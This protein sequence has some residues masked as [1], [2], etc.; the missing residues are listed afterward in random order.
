MIKLNSAIKN[1]TLVILSSLLLLSPIASQ[2][3]PQT[4]EVFSYHD[5][6]DQ[7]DGD[8]AADS[9]A[10]SSYNLARHFAWLKAHGYHPVSVDTILAARNNGKQLP[11]KAILLTFDD[12]YRSF[13]DRVY[14][15]LKLYQFPAVAAVVGGWLSVK[16]GEIVDYGDDKKPREHFLSNSQ[17][18]ELADSG[19]VEIASHSFDLHHGIQSNPQGNKTPAAITRAYNPDSKTYET[20][21]LYEARITADLN[22]NSQFIKEITG[23]RPRVMVWPYGAYNTQTSKIATDSGMPISLSLNDM[24]AAVLNTKNSVIGRFL[25]DQNPDASVLPLLLKR[26]LVVEH[27]RVI[28]IDLDYVYDA[29]LTQMN[30]NIDALLDRIKSLKPSTV[31]LQAFADPDGNGVADALY[32]P[33]RHLPVRADLF[34]R[35]AWQLRT[36]ASVEVYAWM[37][38][39]AYSLPDK[40]LQK[41][42][43]L[44][45]SNGTATSHYQ[46]LSPYS[47]QARQLIKE[48]YEDLGAHANFAGVLFHDDAMMSE[49][50]DD[51]SF[52]RDV[53]VKQWH[54][55]GTVKAIQADA[56]Q[57]NRWQQ[58]KSQWLTQFTLVLANTL[59]DYHPDLK[60]A[61]NLYA[62]V[63]INPASE[64]W[65]GQNY[66]DF[67]AHYD[68][69]AVMAMPY[70]EKVDNPDT[71]LKQLVIIAQKTP[72][73]IK[74]TLFELQAENWRNNKAIDTPTLTRQLKLLLDSGANHVGYYPDDF[75]NNQPNINLIRP[76]ISSRQFPYLGK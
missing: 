6:Q 45:S 18:K 28:H 17:I 34:N 61:R 16:N 3:N 44:V 10:I 25:I 5:V 43:S 8:T 51:S 59:R 40:V 64:R 1:S 15:L 75:I 24:Q 39:L 41:K 33:N 52:A 4:F 47:N 2:A 67:L 55:A 68:Y 31:Y 42:L 29:N 36:R 72:N 46:R 65:L 58:Y 50:E 54:L 11:E 32:F 27:K 19:L 60:T 12:G 21:R 7:L 23:K 49:D 48:I 62:N 30:R 14:P 37:P 35:V 63:M 22:Q 13:Y 74:K 66:A 20:K 57:L 53:Y 69:T 56:T 26:E 70:M 38:V 9:T 76:Y 71:W 73:G